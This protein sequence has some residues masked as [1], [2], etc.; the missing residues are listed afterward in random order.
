MRQFELLKTRKGLNKSGGIVRAR[1]DYHQPSRL[2]ALE[3]LLQ[4]ARYGVRILAKNI[5]FTL[6]ASLSLALGIAASTA[7]FSVIYAVLMNPFPYAGA[8]R[9]VRIEIEDKAG[10]LNPVLLTGSQLDRLQKTQSADSVLGQ[11]DWE[12]ATTGETL[13]QDVRAVFLSPN[14]SDYFG[15]P[16]LFGRGL[17]PSDAPRDVDPQPIAV[18]GFSFWRRHYGGNPNV[19]G[20]ILE[21][22][23]REYSV[24]GVLRPRFAWTLGDVYLPLKITDDPSKPVFVSSIKLKPGVALR[25]AQSEFQVLFEQFARENLQH[26]PANFRIHLSELVGARGDRIR[27]AV[28]L[29]S[30][31]VAIL[32]MI[33]CANASI[34]LFARGVSRQ[35]EL[36][37]RTAVGASRKRLVR[38][39]LTESLLLS[40]CGAVLG[41][42]LAHEVVTLIVKWLP[43][44]MYPPE[45][46]IRV[47]FPV[48][49]FSVGVALLSTILFGVSPALQLSRADVGGVM[50]SGIRAVGPAMLAKR[51]HSLLIACQI[52][53]TLLL[54]SASGAAIQGFRRLIDTKLGYNPRNTMVVGIPVHEN[55]YMT[56]E[57]RAAYFRRLRQEV[58]GVPGVASAAIS[59]LATPPESGID[60]RIEIMGQ[61]T[62]NKDVVR[63]NLVSLEYFNLLEIPLIRGRVWDQAET[64]GGAH[65]AVI[66]ETM[67]RQFWPNG[68]A[69]SSMIRM[70]E[71]KNEP[72]GIAKSDSNQW[73]EV[74]GIVGD[75]RNDGLLNPVKPAVYLPYTVRLEL[76]IQVLVHTI[77]MP[78]PL[79]RTVR[80]SVHLVDADQQVD[81][82]AGTTLEELLSAQPEWQ[83]GR[84]L[85][86]LFTGFSLMAL[87]LSVVGLYSVVSH[88]VAQ[89]TRELGVR[90]ALGAQKSDLLKVVFLSTLVSVGFG[91]ATGIALTVLLSR[92]LAS[93]TDSSGVSLPVLL[94][95][96][97][98]LICCSAI[99]CFLPALRASRVDPVEALR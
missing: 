62:I 69:L 92:L 81:G 54:L 98:L 73:F 53:L 5:G 44:N 15:V 13:P 80:E 16:P 85:T 11:A 88:S 14:A 95:V 70:P 20:K 57:D 25:T 46:T 33:G 7:L 4:D 42:G 51:T 55:A 2:A 6:A 18:L 94:A 17:L 78:R 75:A 48:L 1:D 86:M 99:A 19:I 40:L 84:L 35:S 74:V 96:T 83:Q 32:L 41:I 61:P 90:M 9:M 79:L 28:Y 76:Y 47:N 97:L 63:L 71:F 67:A 77:S 58:A 66:N 45:A 22:G 38:Q 27:Q 60:Q 50:Q 59:T 64:V 29:I 36:A 56:W 31:G 68:G 34:L 12:L 65:V 39:M 43:V 3:A 30:G 21:L 82:D 49:L 24:V 87:V 8:K 52:A 23:H 93:W 72:F 89:R 26:F 91:V 10:V 37:I